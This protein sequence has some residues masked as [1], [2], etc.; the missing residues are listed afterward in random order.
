MKLAANLSWMYTEF[1][2]LDRIPAC[3]E[4][5]FLHAECLFPYE[6]PATALRERADSAGLKWALINAPAGHWAQGD[7][8]LATDPARQKEFR[9]SISKATEYAE[10]LGVGK[11]HVLA[12]LVTPA[13]PERLVSAWACYEDNL[14]WLA[15]TSAGLP[16]DW[17]IEPINQVDMPGYLLSQ[18]AQAH[19]LIQRLNR[20][21]LGIQMDLYHCQRTEG[22][23]L[24]AL[25]HYLPTGRVK[26]LQIAGAPHRTEPDFGHTAAG[27]LD[28]GP[29]FSLLNE[30]GYQG[31]VGCEYRPSAGTRDGLGWIQN[32]GFSGTMEGLKPRA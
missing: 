29:V 17:L 30:L 32:T 19:E 21:N 27:R 8:G 28:Y 2:F 26:H 24:E 1:A 6:F 14:N 11:V 3:V 23:V 16:I 7:R 18:Q 12:G 31:H 9:D 15:D 20:S 4:D 13:E 10:A 5:G 25:A 22:K